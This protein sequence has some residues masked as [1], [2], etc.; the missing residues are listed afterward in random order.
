MYA[1]ADAQD[2]FRLTVTYAGFEAESTLLLELYKRGLE[3]PKIG[4]DLFGG[5]GL[6]MFW[7]HKP[8][9]PWQDEAWAKAMRRE[10]ASA[11]QRQFLNEFATSSSSF[12][13]MHAWDDCGDAR[14][15]PISVDLKLD[16]W[17]GFDGN[18][19]HDQTAIV[20]V[21]FDTASKRVRLVNHKIFQ[22]TPEQPID[23]EAGS[24]KLCAIGAA[25]SG[26]ADPLRSDDDASSR[27]APV[28]DRLPLEEFTQT[29]NNLTAAGQCLFELIN[30]NNLWMYSDL[31]NLSILK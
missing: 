18:F 20:C 10:R 16:V 1:A 15:T 22:P 17:I 19:K 11:Y 27:A 30:G 26:Q 2:R 6:L 14:L 28:R 12:I 9:A 13:D 5:D 3:Q 21:T 24:R 7:S 23:F 29:S 31:V 4:E 8:I 25:I